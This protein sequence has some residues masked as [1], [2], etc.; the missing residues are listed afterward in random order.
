[1]Y[2][3]VAGK[4]NCHL[5]ALS[6]QD[7]FGSSFYGASMSENFIRRCGWA[8]LIGFAFT[9]WVGIM[10]GTPLGMWL[11]LL[12][13]FVSA[14]ILTMVLTTFVERGRPAAL[15]LAAY[16][17]LLGV[18]WGGVARIIQFAELHHE[19][20]QFPDASGFHLPPNWWQLPWFWPGPIFIGLLLMTVA[21]LMV[22]F[23][24]RA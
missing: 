11:R 7:R 18:V 21:L 3:L 5:L 1:M 9:C 20:N 24:P 13:H 4:Y 14:A 6:S 16:G 10:L 2:R 17:A 19:I 15:C 22:L 12:S 23:T 8:A